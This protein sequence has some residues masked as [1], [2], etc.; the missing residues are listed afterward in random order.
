MTFHQLQ[1]M[2]A[3]NAFCSSP[4]IDQLG[5]LHVPFDELTATRSC[6]HA[7]DRALRQGTGSPWSAPRAPGSHPWSNTS[8]PPRSSTGSDH[9][10]LAD[11]RVNY[12][13]VHSF[14]RRIWSAR[15]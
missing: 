2:Q 4:R 14:H 3:L 15:H 12:S 13:G 11:G 5:E 10:S 9:C 8:P 7:L 1:T 6:E